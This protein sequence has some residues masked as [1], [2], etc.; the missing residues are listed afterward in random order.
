VE[1]ISFHAGFGL[2]RDAPRG[3]IEIDRERIFRHEVI[4]VESD[5]EASCGE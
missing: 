4:A 3:R 1:E 5:D 2:G